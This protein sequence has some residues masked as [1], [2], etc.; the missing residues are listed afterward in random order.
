MKS[1]VRECF[2]FCQTGVASEQ[3]QSMIKEGWIEGDGLILQDRPFFRF[4]RIS[5]LQTR[6]FK[7]CLCENDCD[8]VCWAYE[9]SD[10]VFVSPWSLWGDRRCLHWTPQILPIS[11]LNSHPKRSSLE[12]SKLDNCGEIESISV[13]WMIIDTIRLCRVWDTTDMVCLTGTCHNSRQL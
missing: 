2:R 7:T 3:I 8:G 12:V 10:P 5:Y 4:C 6:R 9:T 13:P 1:N 11:D